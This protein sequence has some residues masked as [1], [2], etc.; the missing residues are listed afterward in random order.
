MKVRRIRL[1]GF[2][3]AVVLG[4]A[5]CAP[6]R[7]AGSRAPLAEIDGIEIRNDLAYPVYDVMIEIPST[8][9]FAGCGMILQRSRCA[10]TFP[11]A[12]YRGE[13]LAIRWTEHGEPQGI[14]D[15]VLE[16]PEGAG[17]A[18]RVRLEVTIF[19]PG[20]AGARLLSAPAP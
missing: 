16:P 20:Q 19:A 17:Q 9:G 3:G 13:T 15:V 18:P 4:L 14:D 2:F 6:V 7:D 10:T 8:G 11:S 12:A 1:A 5:A